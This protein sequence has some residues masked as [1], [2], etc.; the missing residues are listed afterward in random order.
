MRFNDRFESFE[1]L[2][3]KAHRATPACYSL[4]KHAQMLHKLYYPRKPDIEWIN[5]NFQ[6]HFSMR[7][8]HIIV[9]KTNNLRVGENIIVNRLSILNNKIPLEWLNLP[10][11]AFKKKIKELFL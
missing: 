10:Y 2:H 9:A 4:Y 8:G 7:Q 3:D 6:N 5:L 11:G 1:A